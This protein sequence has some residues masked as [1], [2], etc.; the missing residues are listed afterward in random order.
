MTAPEQPEQP[1]QQPPPSPE[2]AALEE[3]LAQA[4]GSITPILVTALLA[5][6]AVDAATPDLD[7]RW[8]VIAK[9]ALVPPA[10]IVKA[11]AVGVTDVVRG[12][13]MIILQPLIFRRLL[14][15]DPTGQHS[16]SDL[17]DL[18]RES[19]DRAIDLAAEGLNT[20]STS[21]TTTSSTS[22]TTSWSTS[23]TDS[24]SWS[25][26]TSSSTSSSSSN[27]YTMFE[28]SNPNETRSKKQRKI[29]N[30]ATRLARW[31]TREAVFHAQE[32]IS[33][34]LGYTHKR[35]VSERDSRVR[36]EHRY[37]D[38]MA[39][40]IGDTFITATGNIRYPGDIHAP[41]HLVINCRCSLEWIKRP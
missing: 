37:L 7:M 13:L 30:F 39:V 3:A 15:L 20:F 38:G 4:E 27:I 5:A 25:T 11:A 21:T 35:W 41:L 24:T 36:T 32:K 12:M 6:M 26:S 31:I 34:V 16:S 1:P 9:G 14:D 19:A 18:A 33:T 17:Q 10:A 22:T 40:P 29:E 8:G 23:S 2:V 28:S